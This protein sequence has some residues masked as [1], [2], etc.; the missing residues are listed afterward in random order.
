MYT[1]KAKFAAVM[2]KSV[3]QKS[4][5]TNYSVF[6]RQHYID[7]TI[8]H[9]IAVVDPKAWEHT[10]KNKTTQQMENKN[11]GGKKHLNIVEDKRIE[12]TLFHLSHAALRRTTVSL[13]GNTRGFKPLKHR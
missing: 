6:H 13:H 12:V 2:T 3:L 1:K 5:E 4:T 7:M 8:A 9:S 10:Q 11:I